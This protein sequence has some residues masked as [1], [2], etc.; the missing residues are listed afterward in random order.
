MSMLSLTIQRMTFTGSGVG[1]TE[2]GH[3]FRVA[4]ACVGERI[5]AWDASRPR[6]RA[7]FMVAVESAA[8]EAVAPLCPYASVCGAC[9]FQRLSVET[10]SRVKRDQWRGLIQRFL[11]P[12]AREI[13]TR[14][15]ILAPPK[16][17]GYRHRSL[18]QWRPEGFV[19]PLR[20]DAQVVYEAQRAPEVDP[21]LCAIEKLV[22][23]VPLK[24]CA[25]HADCLQ[26][27]MEEA[28]DVLRAQTRDEDVLLS[29]EFEVEAFE[30]EARLT[31]RPH[32]G[33]FGGIARV[34]SRLCE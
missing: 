22:P 5:R 2:D 24:G 19:M 29:L 13:V 12:E 31:F 23:Y 14:A 20:A 18:A 8:P 32:P 34:G 9:Q 17:L 10:Q 3:Y 28:Q 25:L 33:S 26:A 21:D 7:A 30:D 6:H 27:A 11:P 15:E 1:V 16:S 4:N